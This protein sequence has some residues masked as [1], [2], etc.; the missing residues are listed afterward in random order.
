MTHVMGA[1]PTPATGP[2]TVTERT[3]GGPAHELPVDAS[4]QLP[5]GM[6]R[7]MPSFSRF[8]L[9]F[10]NLSYCDRVIGPV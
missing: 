7:L 6:G 3:S 10:L 8:S 2:R 5:V 4:R 9:T 1:R